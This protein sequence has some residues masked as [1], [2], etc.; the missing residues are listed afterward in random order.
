MRSSMHTER[1][2]VDIVRDLARIAAPRVAEPMLRCLVKSKAREPAGKWLRSHIRFGVQGLVGAG[3]RKGVGG[4]KLAE[5]AIDF[6]RDAMRAGAGELIEAAVAAHEP[7]PGLAKSKWTDEHYGAERIRFEVLDRSDR[8]TGDAGGMLDDA[9]TPSWLTEAVSEFDASRKAARK[10]TPKRPDW[11]ATEAIEPLTIDADGR[12]LD[13]DQIVSVLTALKATASKDETEAA[14]AG[15]LLA[16]IVAHV[17]GE[18]R[19]RFVW[20]LLGLWERNGAPARD[21]WLIAAAGRLGDDRTAIRLAG[22]LREWS[23]ESLHQR[24]RLG[25]DGL[26]AIGTTVALSEVAELSRRR[27]GQLA[28]RAGSML[29][30]IAAERGI[31]REV[32]DDQLVP[33]CGLDRHGRRTFSYGPRSFRLQLDGALEPTLQD[34]T[35][36]VRKSLPRPTRDDDPEAAALA[37]EDWKQTRKQVRAV[38]EVQTQAAG[39]DDDLRPAVGRGRRSATCWSSVP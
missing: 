6:Y 35:G 9:S 18:S 38:V 36:K 19:D 14:A 24:A 21:R 37:A 3:G 1:S 10:R 32:L 11:L 34:E 28:K 23:K 27:T 7:P 15:P 5:A 13:D 26:R 29:D 8:V 33:T 2:A 31:G 39:A 4:R 12:R 30:E 20:S 17:D 22:R 16:A 25:L